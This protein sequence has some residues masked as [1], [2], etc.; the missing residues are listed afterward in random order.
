[1]LKDE[2]VI[3]TVDGVANSQTLL[4]AVSLK[5]KQQP[6]RI[7]VALPVTRAATLKKIKALPSV[8]EVHC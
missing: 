2:I 8:N 5:D 3:M 6:S 4:S 7:L 1:M